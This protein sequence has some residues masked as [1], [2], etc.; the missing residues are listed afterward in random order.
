MAT[1]VGSVES[2][3]LVAMDI[4]IWVRLCKRLRLADGEEGSLFEIRA[5]PL[6]WEVGQ[7]AIMEL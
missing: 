4:K 5:Q 2:V 6:G 1:L 7:L 3:Y